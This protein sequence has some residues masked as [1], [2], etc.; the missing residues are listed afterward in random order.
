MTTTTT[1]TTM[2]KNKIIIIQIFGTIIYVA[3]G[4]RHRNKLYVCVVHHETLSKNTKALPNLSSLRH[5]VKKEFYF[6]A[7]PIYAL[8]N[9]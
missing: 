3:L 1:T 2:K 7:L 9:V 4:K 5:L 8:S 6:R